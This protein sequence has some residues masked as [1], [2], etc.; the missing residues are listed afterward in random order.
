M[1]GFNDL[2]IKTPEELDTYLKAKTVVSILG[3][4]ASEDDAWVIG[5]DVAQSGYSIKT[6]GYATGA[7]RGGLTGG[8]EALST[9]EPSDYKQ[10]ITGVTSADFK[11]I[12]FATKG[13]GISTEIAEDPYER[14]KSLIRDS[15]IVVI[16]EGSIGTD[17]ETYAAFAFEIE[18]EI[19]KNG[20]SEKPVIF[21]GENIKTKVMSVPRFADYVSKSENVAFVDRVDEVIG[22][23][24]VSFKKIRDKK[25]VEFDI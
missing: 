24:D 20:K 8:A 22:L 23:V 5:H 18:L 13:E 17:L 7:M 6:G 1:E 16:T 11:P 10:K 14:L 2:L 4:S 21:V 25:R 15:D 3:G 19:L 9:K 12:E